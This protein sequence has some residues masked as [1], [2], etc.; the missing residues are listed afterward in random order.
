MIWK[1]RALIRM[2][3][4]GPISAL[5]LQPGSGLVHPLTNCLFRYAKSL[6]WAPLSGRQ[7]WVEIDLLYLLTMGLIEKADAGIRHQASS[8]LQLLVHT[9]QAF[10]STFNINSTVLLG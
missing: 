9:Q 10:H 8:C 4:S 5:Q 6:M 3:L 2:L 1:A 7:A